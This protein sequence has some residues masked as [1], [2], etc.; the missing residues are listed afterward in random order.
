MEASEKKKSVIPF[1]NK[2]LLSDMYDML[3]DI[4][5]FTK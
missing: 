1:R 2:Q 4:L 5:E 3:R